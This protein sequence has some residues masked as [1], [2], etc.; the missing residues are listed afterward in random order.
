M[1]DKASR[2]AAGET[3][4]HIVTRQSIMK[5]RHNA[6]SKSC[7]FMDRDN[8]DKLVKELQLRFHPWHAKYR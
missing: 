2:F 3:S 6:T 8:T 1:S 4:N 5:A 7:R